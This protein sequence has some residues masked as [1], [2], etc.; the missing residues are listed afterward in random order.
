MTVASHQD[1]KAGVADVGRSGEGGADRTQRPGD[2]VGH[3]VQRDVVEHDGRHHLVG[4]GVR[5]EEAGDRSVHRADQDGGDEGKRNRHGPGCMRQPRSDGR[6]REAT[7][8]ELTLRSDVEEP[9]LEGDAHRQPGQDER[10]RVHD[11]RDDRSKRPEGPLHERLVG[12]QRQREVQA[13]DEW[14]REDHD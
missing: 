1:R 4:A 6:G 3:D 14:R 8:Q 12:D 5:L 11:R 10:C 2:Y 13:E 9:R 7:R